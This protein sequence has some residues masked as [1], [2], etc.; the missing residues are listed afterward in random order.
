MEA[1]SVYDHFCNRYNEDEIQREEDLNR[2][3]EEQ[4]NEAKKRQRRFFACP[5]EELEVPVYS[6][7]KD[8]NTHCI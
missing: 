7:V 5:G 6:A 3:R 8:L 4:E 2:T 1:V